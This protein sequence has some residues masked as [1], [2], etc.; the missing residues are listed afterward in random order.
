MLGGGV[1]QAGKFLLAPVHEALEE[2]KSPAIQYS[3][4]IVTAELGTLSPL[5]GAVGFGTRGRRQG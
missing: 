2:L 3:T 5:F 4:E 1:V